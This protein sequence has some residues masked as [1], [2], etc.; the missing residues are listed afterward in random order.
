MDLAKHYRTDKSAEENGQWVDWGD[1]TK[2]LIA[3]LG[4]PQ[5]QARFQ[6]LI[7]PHRH[8]RDRGLLADEI[9]VE[10][11]GKCLA[12]TVLL[13]WEGVEYD[14]SPL[15]YSVENALKMLTEFKDFREDIVTISGEQATYRAE[16]IEDSAKNSEKS[17]DGKTSGGNTS[18]G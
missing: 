15:K 6:A 7:K 1:G 5:Y 16:E 17:S 10:I 9:Q 13:D 3:R 14:G 8:L 18:K 12:E 11:L 2:F 4:N